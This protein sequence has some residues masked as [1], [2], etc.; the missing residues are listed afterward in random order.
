[1]DLQTIVLKMAQVETSRWPRL[2]YLFQVRSTAVAYQPRM[3]RK[4]LRISNVNFRETL[5]MFGDKC[6]QNGS[7]NNPM[8][9]RTT[10][11]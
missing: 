9:P 3:P 6:P 8:A 4:A 2:A 7:K 5:S 11:E 1:M 10:L